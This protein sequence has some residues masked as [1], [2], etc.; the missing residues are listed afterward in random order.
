[1]IQ[2]LITR[3]GERAG[4]CVWLALC[5]NP[6]MTAEVTSEG[7]DRVKTGLRVWG[8]GNEFMAAGFLEEVALGL[9]QGQFPGSG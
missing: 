5:M 6:T 1:M 3:G 8:R 9:T 7:V 2:I 4:A